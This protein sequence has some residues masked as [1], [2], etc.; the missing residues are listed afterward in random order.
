M[1]RIGIRLLS[2]ASAIGLCLAGAYPATAAGNID[3]GK[4]LNIG[5]TANYFPLSGFHR[6]PWTLS[7]GLRAEVL[8]ISS[9]ALL[10]S[11]LGEP[12]AGERWPIVKALEQFG[13]FTGLQPVDRPNF[14]LTSQGRSNSVVGLSTFDW[15]KSRYRSRYVAFVHRDLKR[16]DNSRQKFVAYQRLLSTESTLYKKYAAPDPK[17]ADPVVRTFGTLP[18]VAVGDYLQVTSQIINGGDFQAPMSASDQPGPWLPFAAIQGSL[19]AGK[20]PAGIRLVEDVNS[21]ANIITA[22]ICHADGSQPARVCGRAVIK[23]MLRHVK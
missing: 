11:P 14:T 17:S 20:D 10:I 19:A 23:S 21:E 12:E 7:S 22:L 9:G 3:L 5:S 18:L 6:I 8:V 15:S 4:P 1:S 16:Y 13:T 2:I